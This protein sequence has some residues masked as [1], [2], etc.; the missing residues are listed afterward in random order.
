MLALSTSMLAFNGP[1]MMPVT[2][3]VYLAP[4]EITMG[5]KV[6][7]KAA[8]M[9][10]PVTKAAPAKATPAKAVPVKVTPVKAA[11]VKAAPVKAPP[12]KAATTKV[13]VAKPAPKKASAASKFSYINVATETTYQDAKLEVSKQRTFDEIGVLPPIGRWDP[14]K[15]RE[16]GPERYRRFV[17]MEIKHG[18]MA[19]AAVAGVLTTYAGFRFPGYISTSLDLK[20]SDIPGTMIGSWSTVPESGW[21]QIILFIVLLETQW[22]RQDPNKAAGDVVPDG[23]WW[24]RYDDGYTI[25]LGDTSVKTVPADELF[26]G[27]TWKLNAERNNGRAAMMGITGMLTHELLTGNPVYPLGEN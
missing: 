26:L 24:A 5:A 22:F 23:T 10:A 18:R 14:L 1:A 9:K 12:V 13:T 20:F 7:A 4:A 17:E 3:A 2:H 16:Q 11:A 8:P 19:M 6:A 21:L 27:K 15:I 25:W